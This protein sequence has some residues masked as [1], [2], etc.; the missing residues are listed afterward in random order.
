[1]RRKLQPQI[2]HFVAL[3]WLDGRWRICRAALDLDRTGAACAEA[4]AI[5]EAGIAVVRAD[6]TSSEA[7]RA[8]DLPIGCRKE[9]SG[10]AEADRKVT[11]CS[12][13]QAAGSSEVDSD[14]DASRDMKRMGRVLELQP[15]LFPPCRCI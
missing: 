15:C 12:F 11:V 8:Q 10:L 2:L 6:Q 5:D 13:R 1:M 4:S 3:G 7:G 9:M 14:E